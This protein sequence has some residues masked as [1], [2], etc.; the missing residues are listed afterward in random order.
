MEI[1]TEGMI[2][3]L[4]DEQVLYSSRHSHA[5]FHGTV[6]NRNQLGQTHKYGM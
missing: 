5:Y 6:W 4:L 2:D 1:L 3:S